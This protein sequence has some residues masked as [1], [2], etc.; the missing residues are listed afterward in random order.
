MIVKDATCRQLRDL[1]RHLCHAPDSADD[2]F[3]AVVVRS[4]KQ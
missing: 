3:A 4:S 2:L 1:D